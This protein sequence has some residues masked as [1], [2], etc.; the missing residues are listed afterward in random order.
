[1][2]FYLSTLR[3][4]PAQSCATLTVILVPPRINQRLPYIPDQNIEADC[5]AAFSSRGSFIPGLLVDFL[6]DEARLW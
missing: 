4:R 2:N 1:M 5:A 3:L 6:V